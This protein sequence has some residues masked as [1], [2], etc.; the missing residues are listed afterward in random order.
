M[1]QLRASDKEDA[2]VFAKSTQDA[3]LAAQNNIDQLQL[4]LRAAVEERDAAVAVTGSANEE[5]TALREQVVSFKVGPS[6]S[7]SLSIFLRQATFAAHLFIIVS[8]SV[9]K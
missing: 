8:G 9:S 2:K 4:Q 3:L 1:E 6:T 5:V 7:H